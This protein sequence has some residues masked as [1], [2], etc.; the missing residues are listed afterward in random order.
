[1]A[2]RLSMGSFVKYG[3]SAWLSTTWA[4]E[5]LASILYSRFSWSEAQLPKE[6]RR[7]WGVKGRSSFF[8]ISTSRPR[9]MKMP[10]RWGG[11]I[12]PL[13][14]RGFL[15]ANRRRSMAWFGNGITCALSPFIR[16]SG[17]VR[18]SASQSTSSQTAS[19]ISPVRSSVRAM[20]IKQYFSAHQKGESLIWARYSPSSSYGADR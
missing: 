5:S 18:V 15:Q 8:V 4:M 12:V 2:R 7:P 20:K 10:P 11:K 16:S 17:I 6:A 1:M 14:W 3:W 19:S 13:E 9:P